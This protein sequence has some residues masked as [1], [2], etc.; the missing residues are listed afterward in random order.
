ML[1]LYV[2]ATGRHEGDNLTARGS[3][4]LV[5]F[6]EWIPSLGIHYHL[7]VDGIS[8]LLVLLTTFL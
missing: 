1:W 3:M 6:G 4:Q 5:E 8:I 2:G 7:G